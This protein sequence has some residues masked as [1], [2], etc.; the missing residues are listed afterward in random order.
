MSKL[1]SL[2]LVV[3][4]N[5]V[6]VE[7]SIESNDCENDV[8]D[9]ERV[10]KTLQQFLSLFFPGI[11]VVAPMKVRD[12]GLVSVDLG[13]ELEPGPRTEVQEKGPQ[14]TSPPP[15]DIRVGSLT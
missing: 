1:R 9:E 12:G 11:L 3:E 7:T 2:T 8:L 6:V 14:E 5:E 15:R 4:T 10:C 13:M